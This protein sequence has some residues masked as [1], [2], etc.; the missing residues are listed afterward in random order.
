MLNSLQPRLD[1]VSPPVFCQATYPPLL[2]EYFHV[3]GQ[4]F[5]SFC[6]FEI[7]LYKSSFTYNKSN[8]WDSNIWGIVW[9]RNKSYMEHF[10]QSVFIWS[11]VIRWD[12]SKTICKEGRVWHFFICMKAIK[13][14]AFIGVFT[15]P[16]LYGVYNLID[17]SR[18]LLWLLFLLKLKLMELL[19]HALNS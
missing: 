9:Q 2:T 10:N 3:C 12:F 4:S 15:L 13:R 11:D 16:K 17:L 14:A 5:P 7:L 19:T 1:C 6:G 18:L 8:D